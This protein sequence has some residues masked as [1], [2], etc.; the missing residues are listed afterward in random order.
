MENRGGHLRKPWDSSKTTD[1]G[2]RGRPEA[3]RKERTLFKEKAAGNA[4]DLRK[5]THTQV[6]DAQSFPDTTNS[7]APQ[8]TL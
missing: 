3:E 8:S 1:R 2:T 5:E 7:K 4:P 6:Q